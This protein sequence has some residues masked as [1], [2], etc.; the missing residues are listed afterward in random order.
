MFIISVRASIQRW[1]D[2][3]IIYLNLW[4]VCFL[5][6]ADFGGKT[7]MSLVV[8]GWI[9][10]RIYWTCRWIQQML[11]LLWTENNPLAPD[12]AHFPPYAHYIISCCSTKPAENN[13]MRPLSRPPCG[14]GSSSGNP[15][16]PSDHHWTLMTLMW[17]LMWILMC[18]NE[19]FSCVKRLWSRAFCRSDLWKWQK[20]LSCETSLWPDWRTVS[21]LRAEDRTRTWSRLNTDPAGLCC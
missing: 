2:T 9:C 14:S 15:P 20:P 19:S 21:T 16:R 10:P 7:E 12:V 4:S 6:V 18:C 11:L 8:T 1:C 17:I 5:A 3:I 13:T